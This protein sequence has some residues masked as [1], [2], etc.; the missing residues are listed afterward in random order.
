M[1]TLAVAAARKE[2]LTA[3]D[4]PKVDETALTNYTPPTDEK[5]EDRPA[6]PASH[7]DWYRNCQRQ[8]HMVTRFIGAEWK[9]PMNAALDLIY[10]LIPHRTVGQPRRVGRWAVRQRAGGAADGVS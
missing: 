6:M 2:N 3:A 8:I 7:A 10:G 4:F 1:F 5:L 9:E